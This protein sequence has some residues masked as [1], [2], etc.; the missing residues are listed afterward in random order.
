MLLTPVNSPNGDLDGDCDVD[1]SDLLFL[2][3]D[4][5]SQSLISDLNGD[6]I[7]NVFDLLI[8]LANWS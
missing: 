7:V 2:L 8:L 6:G 3:D 4:W 1:V 5:G